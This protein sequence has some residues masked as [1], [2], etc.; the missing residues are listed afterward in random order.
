MRLSDVKTFLSSLDQFTIALPDGGIV[1]G[2]FHV[3]EVGEVS[4]NFIDC[5]GT[6][7]LERVA[8]FQLW[9]AD[10]YDHRLEPGKLIKIIEIAEQ[11]LGLGNLEV[12]VEYQGATTIEKFGLEAG[13]GQL[14]LTPKLTDCLA[15]DK[16]GIP[17]PKKMISLAGFTAKENGGCT[18]GGGCC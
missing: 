1:P 4:K 9:S 8:N 2:H 18:P 6:V 10:D 17:A 3:T 15:K 13:D 16:C 5:G 12:E 11:Q 14:Q 7:R